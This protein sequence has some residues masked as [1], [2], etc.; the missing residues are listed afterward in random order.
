[1]SKYDFG[2]DI[3]PN[4][5]MEWALKNIAF[6]SK[7][8][9]LGPAVGT[10]TKHLKEER[11]CTI[12]IVEIDDEAGKRAAQYARRSCI[13][14]V[15]GDA[16]RSDW[17]SKLENERYDY[18]VMLDVIE[19]LRFP[20]ELFHRLRNLLKETGTI[21]LS[22]PNIAHNSIIL[23]LLNNTFEYTELGLLD[24]TH[25]HFF[26]D[27]SLSELLKSVDLYPLKK[28]AIQLRVGE[29]EIHNSYTEIPQDIE[30]FLRTREGADVYQL[31]FQINKNIDG[32][33]L[34]LKV[35][36]LP[37]TL[38][39]FEA[40]DSK[41]QIFYQQ[42]INP[43]TKF[44]IKFKV[45][46]DEEII[47]FNLL[48]SVCIIRNLKILGVCDSSKEKL[49]IVKS[50]AANIGNFYIFTQKDPQIFVEKPEGVTDIEIQYE[51]VTYGT[52]NAPNVIDKMWGD[53]LLC[54]AEIQDY[55]KEQLRQVEFNS[56]LVKENSNLKIENESI[57][58]EK[59][60]LELEIEELKEAL[61][62]STQSFN[63]IK[64]KWWYK[65]F[66]KI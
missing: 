63:M 50:N 3:K 58:Q 17:Y 25:V 52:L 13:G 30:A 31:L 60:K 21:L 61:A 19:H 66:N 57:K 11:Q 24:K 45:K 29:N 26:T 28:E 53:L 33:I 46:S 4:S 64:G 55:K 36:S 56:E 51:C 1:M 9:E 12:D 49:Q 20:V 41:N 34:P 8:L 48:D 32:A 22:T 42:F 40:M 38:Y 15:E 6:G 5:T 39:K 2:E 54:K 35:E 18:I 59:N 14:L 43:R 7:V 37:Y 62:K 44:Q 47:R 65:I 16:D 27:K 10:L 23:E